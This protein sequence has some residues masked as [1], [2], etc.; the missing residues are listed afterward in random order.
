[1][2]L[3]ENFLLVPAR[4]ISKYG[5]PRAYVRSVHAMAAADTRK[6]REKFKSPLFFLV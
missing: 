2:A 5:I 6:E 1:M 4:D 3:P